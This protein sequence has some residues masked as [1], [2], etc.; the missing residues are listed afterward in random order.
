[1][2]YIIFALFI[3]TALTAGNCDKNCISCSSGNSCEVCYRTKHTSSGMCGAATPHCDLNFQGEQ[4]SC[5]WCSVGYAYDYST[6]KC[7]QPSGIPAD[8]RV[9]IKY[10]G[11]LY[12]GICGNGS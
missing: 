8:C 7:T 5:G 11:N 9:A 4:G 6:N 1:M 10:N 12:C 3:A 2:K